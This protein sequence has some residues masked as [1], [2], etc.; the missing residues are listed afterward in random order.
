MRTRCLISL[1]FTWNP[2]A[3]I[4]IHLLVPHFPV[5]VT[6]KMSLT[7][8]PKSQRWTEEDV[9]VMLCALN[10][11]VEEIRAEFETNKRDGIAFAADRL[12]KAVG[13]GCNPARVK[14]KMEHLWKEGGPSGGRDVKPIDPLY[15]FGAW[16]RTLPSLD[17]IYP[18]MLKKIAL[19][20]NAQER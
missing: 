19:A 7:E 9:L 16:T 4:F 14:G 15:R 20:G 10:S 3:H 6:G 5:S 18:G 8:I 2:A 1:I 17:A 13:N 11:N 12:S